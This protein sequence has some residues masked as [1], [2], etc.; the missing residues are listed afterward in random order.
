MFSSV[1]LIKANKVLTSFM[2]SSWI[3]LWVPVNAVF[4]ADAA[5]AAAATIDATCKGR[6]RPCAPP[7]NSFCHLL[8]FAD[9]DTLVRP[10][11]SACL[12]LTLVQALAR[13]SDSNVI[14]LGLFN[15][16]WGRWQP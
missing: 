16:S 10:K 12:G 13:Q 1:C 6:V 15:S 2:F 5:A 14:F 9:H 11:G 3:N 4:L 7:S 8:I